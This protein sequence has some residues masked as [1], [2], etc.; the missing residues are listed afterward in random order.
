MDYGRPSTPAEP[1]A[2][3]VS[4]HDRGWVPGPPEDVYR[5][6][7]SLPTYPSWWSDIR[8]DER[9]T[10][11]HVTLTLPA[12]G[13]V[14]ASVAGKR[15]GVGV[16]IQMAGDVDG[17]LEWFLEPSKEGTVVNGL[18][19]LATRPRRWNRRERAYRSAIRNGLVALRTVF[20]DRATARARR[21]AP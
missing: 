13:R 7:E 21:E 4:V 2:P 16:I 19:R 1:Y 8:I 12:L 18:L 9:E 11:R 3:E 6:V 20:E 14:K 5:I 10:E 15:P 17:V